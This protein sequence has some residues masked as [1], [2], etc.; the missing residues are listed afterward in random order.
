MLLSSSAFVFPLAVLNTVLLA[1][2]PGLLPVARSAAR[3]NSSAFFLPHI[4]LLQPLSTTTSPGRR[5]DSSAVCAICASSRVDVLEEEELD[6]LV[7]IGGFDKYP[8]CLHAIHA[9]FPFASLAINSLCPCKFSRIPRSS[10][11]PGCSVG[12]CSVLSTL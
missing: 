1:F 6:E 12:F 8:Y 4:D 2:V 5:H 9:H 11:N 10:C 7:C 3:V